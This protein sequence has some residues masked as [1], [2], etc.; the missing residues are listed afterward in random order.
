[1]VKAVQG[2]R[3]LP[4]IW[5]TGNLVSLLD[6][7]VEEPNDHLCSIREYERGEGNSVEAE[8]SS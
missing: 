6:G 8:A 5:S 1:V 3:H 2:K 4:S 7:D